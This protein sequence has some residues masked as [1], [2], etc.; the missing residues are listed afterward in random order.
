ML[1]QETIDRIANDAELF[2]DKE[3][4]D[5]HKQPRMY[6]VCESSYEAGATTEATRA[7][8]REQRLV[9]ALEMAKREIVALYK[10][11]GYSGSFVT[12]TIDEA[13]T[14]YSGEGRGRL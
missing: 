12:R 8:E 7:I 11:K 6:D 2:A 3:F 1:P 5:Y 10:Q 14:N 9:E 4:P 13:L